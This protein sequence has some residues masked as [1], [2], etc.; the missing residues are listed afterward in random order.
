MLFKAF[1]GYCLG[2]WACGLQI[3]FILIVLILHFFVL[4]FV[5]GWWLVS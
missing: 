5:I 2:A 3:V 4:D 1:G